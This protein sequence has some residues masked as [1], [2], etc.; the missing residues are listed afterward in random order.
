[1]LSEDDV[2]KELSTIKFSES[3]PVHL[4]KQ[5][6]NTRKIR[7]HLKRF[8]K[9]LAAVKILTHDLNQCEVFKFI[10][11]VTFLRTNVSVQLWI[12]LL[13]LSVKYFGEMGECI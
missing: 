6:D 1:M 10:R 5:P 9:I 3:F 12:V 4:K 13:N 7:L 8:K 11:N 2:Y